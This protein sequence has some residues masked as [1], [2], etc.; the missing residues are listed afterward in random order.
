[1]TFIAIVCPSPYLRRPRVL[2]LTTHADCRDI[3]C[4]S[5]SGPP[6]LFTHSKTLDI[7]EHSNSWLSPGSIDLSP[8][9]R[10]STSPDDPDCASAFPASNAHE[11]L[12]TTSNLSI[13]PNSTGTGCAVHSTTGS[14]TSTSSCESPEAAGHSPSQEL[15]PEVQRSSPPVVK[16]A[17]PRARSPAVEVVGLQPL[18][19]AP[20]GNS[21]KQYHR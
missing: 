11:P 21:V 1:M 14:I 19:K 7:L 12:P 20:R 17:L 16:E 18:K 15:G 2:N 6:H 10:N 4:S 3:Q 5:A 9:D 8:F 13:S